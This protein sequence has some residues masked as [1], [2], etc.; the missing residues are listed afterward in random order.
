MKPLCDF[1]GAARAI[2]Y[3]KSDSAK[4][5]LSCDG[6]V[7]SA[8]ALSQRH[9]R[10]L[11]CDNCHSEPA[12]VRCIEDKLSLCENCSASGNCCLDPGHRRKT[13]SYYSGCPAITEPSKELNARWAHQGMMAM[14]GW[15]SGQQEQ[16]DLMV[17]TKLNE[18]EPCVSSETWTGPSSVVTTKLNGLETC[19]SSE[20]WTGTSS[21]VPPDV[22]SVHCSGDKPL[23]YPE[24]PNLSKGCSPLKDV[25]VSD[26]GDLCDGFNMDD[27]GLNFENS[28]EIFGCSQSH[29]NI[30]LDDVPIDS[31]FMD[32]NFSVADSNGPNENTIEASSS[33]QQDCMS[34][35]SSC[36]AGSASGAD[37]VLLN[38]GCYRNIRL[39]FPTGQVH[40]GMPLP[41][42]NLIGESSIADYQDCGVSPVFLSSESPWDSNLE[43]S[44]PQARDKAKL[45]YN[46]KKKTRMFGKQIRYASSTLILRCFI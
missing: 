21:V 7:H 31:L 38:P 39:N 24:N 18:L 6:F 45:R 44:C 41:F 14:N 46:E 35:Q 4:L 5:C 28:D 27:I 9:L 8:N 33:G 1:C 26:G 29:P 37:Q 15:E 11:I 3:C 25:G 13:L 43:T 12:V 40:S 30:V 16:H 17:T 36:A 2:V 10:S 42:S 34:L 19:V 20:T 32:K 22:N 23:S